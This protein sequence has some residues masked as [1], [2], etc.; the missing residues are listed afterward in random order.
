MFRIMLAL[1]ILVASAPASAAA[2]AIEGQW[3]TDDRKG[4]VRI[5]PCGRQMCGT[6]VR[7]LDTAPGTPTRD[8]NNPDASRR[9]RP[10]LGLQVLWGF[11]PRAAAW[12][13]G[14]AYDPKNGKN[15]RSKLTLNRDGS[16]KVTGCVLFVCR[17]KRWTRF[18]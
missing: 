11:E 16:L 18:Q 6:I 9:T 10:I 8:V 1:A 7:V 15:Y 14:R 3:L 17:S 13:G 4:V 12:E 5:A 2:P